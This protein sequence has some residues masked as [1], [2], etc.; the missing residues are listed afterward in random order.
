MQKTLFSKIGVAWLVIGLTTALLSTSC[1]LKNKKSLRIEK[2]SQP[3][4][5]VRQTVEYAMIGAI[6]KKSE[7]RRIYF[8]KYHQPGKELVKSPTGN[9]K[10]AQLIIGILGGR[11]PYTVEVAY[12]VEKYENGKYRLSHYDKRL[13]RKYY[14]FVQEY[15]ASRPDGVDMIDDFRPY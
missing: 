15:L 1:S 11:S 13:A 8:S 2:I 12:R 7:N 10:R 4:R 3:L 6:K 9:I 14:D 5:I